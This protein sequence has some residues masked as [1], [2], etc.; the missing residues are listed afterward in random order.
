MVGTASFTLPQKIDWLL[1]PSCCSGSVRRCF[2]A[3]GASTTQTGLS[4]TYIPQKTMVGK[5]P[6]ICSITFIGCLR[7][8]DKIGSIFSE[9]YWRG[10]RWGKTQVILLTSTRVPSG[11]RSAN[12]QNGSVNGESVSALF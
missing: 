11:K 12:D 5:F 8:L 7:T 4:K 3:T 10:S 9:F 2:G 1:R 6:T